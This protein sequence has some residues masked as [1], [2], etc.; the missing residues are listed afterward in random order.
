MISYIPS[1]QPVI[2][3][4]NKLEVFDIKLAEEALAAKGQQP[5]PAFRMNKQAQYQKC[6]SKVIEVKQVD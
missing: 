5:D 6:F 2:S 4:Q 1:G 3:S